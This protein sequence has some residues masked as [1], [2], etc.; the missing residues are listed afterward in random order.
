MDKYVT[1]YQSSYMN[2]RKIAKLGGAAVGILVLV[3]LG[4]MAYRMAPR[5]I[6][7]DLAGLRTSSM[8]ILNDKCADCHSGIKSLPFYSSIPVVGDIVSADNKKGIRH[9]DFTDTSMA[10]PELAPTNSQGS[11]LPIALLNKLDRTI[12]LDN[13]PPLK[14]KLVHWGSGLS[15]SE[16]EILE[17]WI[18]GERALWL[19][20]WGLEKYADTALQPLPD[21]LPVDAAKVALGN[22]LYHDNRLSK[23]D[24]ISCASC[25]S[26]EKGG[27]DNKSFSPGVG[28]GLGGVNAPTSFNAVFH[29][30]QF[31]DGRA[32]NLAEQAGG[33]PLNPVEMASADWNEII[34]KLKKDDEFTKKFLAVYPDGYTGDTICNAI[35]EYEK[36]L[37]TPN[38]RFDLFLKGD[39]KALTSEEQMGY[40]LFLDYGCATCHSGPAMGGQ[41]FEYMNLKDDYF[42]TKKATDGDKGLAAHSK[43]DK[44]TNR[45]KVPTLRNVELTFPYLH[46]GSKQTLEEAVAAMMQ[47]Q[48]GKKQ[49]TKEEIDNI[50]VFLRTLTGKLNATGTAAHISQESK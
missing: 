27:T 22:A 41:S 16:R 39:Q 31:W 36:T 25:H 24:T 42:A 19:K 23:D 18:T 21:A 49:P 34:G 20:Q 1:C 4:Q 2:R 47:Y 7:A 10:G 45:F 29:M 28:G 26:L 5:P 12:K 14:Y 13:M 15:S 11:P 30:R 8:E 44:D 38:S 43:K 32:S 50:V 46:D 6:P 48:V 9:Y 3:G 35:A 33:P 40:K 37:I 17:K